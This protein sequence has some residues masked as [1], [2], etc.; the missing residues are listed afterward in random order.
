M[1]DKIIAVTCL[2]ESYIQG[3][4]FILYQYLFR[5]G[6]VERRRMQWGSS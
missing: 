1:A 2:S 6:S 5:L 3:P 4:V